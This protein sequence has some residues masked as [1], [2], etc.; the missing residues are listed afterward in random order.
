MSNS[1]LH[2]FFV[3]RALSEAIAEEVEYTL[4]HALSNFGKAD[5]EQ[6][7]RLKNFPQMVLD[8]AAAAESAARTG[9]PSPAS[10]VANPPARD[11]QETLDDLRAEIA[12]LRSELQKYRSR[13]T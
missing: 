13:S 9:N 6:Q 11:L 12:Q 7:E 5:A 4:T 10:P 1:P 3:G 8:R 2:A